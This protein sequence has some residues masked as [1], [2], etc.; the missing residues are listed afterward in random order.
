MRRPLENKFSWSKS[1]AEVF[2]RCLREYYWNAYGSWGGWLRSAPQATRQA[3]LLKKLENRW[4]WAGKVT[5]AFIREY[6]LAL[7]KGFKRPADQLLEHAKL[8]MRAD[9]QYS[10][11]LGFRDGDKRR[12]DF[13]GLLEHY[14]D[15]KHP[16]EEWAAMW[17]RVEQSLTW[18]L[19]SRWP[20]ELAG[21]AADQVLELDD[22][23]EPVM[24][25]GIA[26]HSRP[27]LAYRSGPGVVTVA[28]WKSTPNEKDEDQV[29]GQ[30]RHLEAKGVDGEKRGWLV[31][32]REGIEREVRVSPEDLKKFDARFIASATAMQDLLADVGSNTP[33]SID[34][35]AM[36]E[37]LNKCRTCRYRKL[38]GRE[39]AL[40]ETG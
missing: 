17:T 2:D 27:D 33:K 11:A 6:L 4:G 25:L 8:L 36:T 16:K 26:L 7:F 14:Y 31:Y 40:A 12:A 28:D 10:A 23:P 39:G 32:L 34:A 24:H 20:R 18:W 19:E 9:L 35:F 37:D 13:T 5:H 29:A 38:C 3:Y 15:E 1:R 30:V 21:V 22:N